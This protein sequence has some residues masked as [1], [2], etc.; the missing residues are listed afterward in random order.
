[1]PDSITHPYLPNSPPQTRK[2]M[3]E[4]IGL[5]DVE[6]LYTDIPESVR[7]KE[8]LKIPRS[9]PECEVRRYIENLLAKNRTASDMPCFLGAGCWNHHVPAAVDYVV[10]RSEFATSYTPYQAEASQGILQEL[11]EYQSMIC[12]LT[13]MEY[14]NSSMYDWPTALGEAARMAARV[15]GRDELLIPHYTGP[16]RVATLMTY[17]EPAGIRIIRIAQDPHTGQIIPEDLERKI[18]DR[19]AAVYVENPS[20]LGC[21][22][23]QVDLISDLAH[24]KGSLLVVGVDPISLGVVRPPGDYGADIVIGEGQPLGNHMNYGGPTLGIFACSDGRLLR[25]MP[26]RIIGLT[27]TLDGKDV[28]YCMVHQ[29]REQH[30]RRER[31][32]SNICTNEALCAVAAAVYLSLMGPAGLRRLCE[33]IITKCH[34]AMRVLNRLDGVKAPLLD[35]FHFKEFTV[36]FDDA[37]RSAAAIHSELLKKGIHGGK[38]LT[39]FPELGQTA[40]YCVTEVHSRPDIDALADALSEI[41]G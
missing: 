5:H 41:L 6:Q 7:L 2:K 11:F 19:T 12:E 28:A 39:E 4:V 3:L 13:E 26:G 10:N 1:M 36:N 15:T 38:V 37:G 18:T 31:A 25:Q 14:A 23:S 27:S 17:T 8:R 35:A 40:L 29:T 32:T 20:F 24:R 33:T 9:M 16:E 21:Y 34:Y 30:I 22:E